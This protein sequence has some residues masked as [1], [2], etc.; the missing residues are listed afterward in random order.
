MGN[1]N[2]DTSAGISFRDVAD[3]A[4]QVGAEHDGR[5][6]FEIH[7]PVRSGHG[8]LL[9]VRACL[10]RPAGSPGTWIDC[11]G[12]SGKWPNGQSSTFAGLL[13]RLAYELTAKLD[14]EK[15]RAQRAAAGQLRLI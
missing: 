12:S 2:R 1:D 4:R 11:A 9:E 14:E 8:T 6:H 3:L 15:E 13:F 7:L 5:V 10:S